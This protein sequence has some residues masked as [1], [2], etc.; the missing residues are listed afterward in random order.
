MHPQDD[1]KKRG[2]QQGVAFKPDDPA[3]VSFRIQF[4]HLDHR[5]EQAL[6]VFFGKE[7]GIKDIR[8]L[9]LFDAQ[10]IDARSQC[11]ETQLDEDGA[12]LT[13][14]ELEG[15]EIGEGLKEGISWN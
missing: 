11:D 12:A 9:A 1:A 5:A 8:K 6:R 14:S 7:I 15:A 10:V 13:R 3:R 2:L 4:D